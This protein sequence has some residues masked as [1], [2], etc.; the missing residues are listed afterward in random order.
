M[1]VGK[2]AKVYRLPHAEAQLRGLRGVREIVVVMR[3][4]DEAGSEEGARLEFFVEEPTVAQRV[5]LSKIPLG[6]PHRGRGARL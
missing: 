6:N 4:N 2:H 5:Y 1:R 3:K